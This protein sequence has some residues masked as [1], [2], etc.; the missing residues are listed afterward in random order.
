MTKPIL[1]IGSTCVDIIINIHHLPVTE[2]N[3]R[4]T[5]QS[6]ALGGCAFNAANI[7]RQ[8]GAEFTF[9]S[10]VG[11]GVY[12]DYVG[13]CLAE[14]G[15]PIQVRVPERENG[16]CYCLV[17]EGGERTFMSYHGVEY[18][19]KKEW[20]AG[21]QAQD[22]GMVYVCG[23]EVEEDT[24]EE[25]VDWLAENPGPE[26]FFAPG[27]RVGRIPRERLERLLSLHP[28]LHINEQ[29]S[30]IL[31]GCEDVR[32][33]AEQIR[34]R[35]GNSVIVTLGGE[36]AFCLES[37]ER[38]GRLVTAPAVPAQVADTIGAGDSHIGAL[39]ACLQRGMDMEAA[40][41]KANQISS[42]V[43]G[44]KGASLEDEAARE[45][46]KQRL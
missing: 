22:Y 41:K 12:G 14:R 34:E 2:E 46:W 33:A 25:L 38:G 4:P 39:M 17:E 16:C 31:S 19:F 23:L 26:I 40:L 44:V 35:T 6:M 11:G 45:L 18:T 1:V 8:A 9:I 32:Q 36:G 21:C 7:L 28:V 15:F 27:P 3:I 30:R 20:M 29:E 24:G 10:P 42:A 13:K 43:V 5:S 37:R